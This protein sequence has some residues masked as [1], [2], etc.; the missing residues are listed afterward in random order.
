MLFE[1]RN[2]KNI[3]LS[4]SWRTTQFIF[5]IIN[6]NIKLEGGINEKGI[7]KRYR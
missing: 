4:S 2:I 1:N 5:I 7:K 6:N 3:R